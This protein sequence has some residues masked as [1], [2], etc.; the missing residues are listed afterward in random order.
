[1][2]KFQLKLYYDEEVVTYLEKIW[3]GENEDN[4]KRRKQE[5]EELQHTKCTQNINTKLKK[6]FQEFSS[7]S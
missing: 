3:Q 6:V 7:W 5:Q 1:M 4:Q 2:C